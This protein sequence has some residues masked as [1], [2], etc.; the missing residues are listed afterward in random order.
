MLDLR[1]DMPPGASDI[2]GIAQS[3]DGRTEAGRTWFQWA[4]KW[5]VLA[6]FLAFSAMGR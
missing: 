5:R 4:A 1:L 3:R 6:S 2:N